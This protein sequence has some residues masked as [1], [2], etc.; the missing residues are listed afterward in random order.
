M[1]VSASKSGNSEK[2]DKLL[3]RGFKNWEERYSNFYL[4]LKMLK[5]VENSNFCRDR[6]KNT[7]P[8]YNHNSGNPSDKKVGIFQTFLPPPF[9]K[10]MLR[11]LV[12]GGRDVLDQ[13]LAEQENLIYCM[14]ELFDP[15]VGSQF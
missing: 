8:R 14:M 13:Y 7:N 11:C 3:R 9:T 10:Y 15:E 5:P 12:H 6:N 1:D 2:S 4:K